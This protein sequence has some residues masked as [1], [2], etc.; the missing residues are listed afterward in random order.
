MKTNTENTQNNTQQT[1]NHSLSV[2]K[3]L[4]VTVS[5]FSLITFSLSVVA[6]IQHLLLGEWARI[7][8]FSTLFSIGFGS[9]I[10]AIDKIAGP[11]K[12]EHDTSQ[13]IH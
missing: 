9:F 4:L 1:E 3:Q 7:L 10:T 11:L 6:L 2:L 5:V 12:Q 8:V 13:K